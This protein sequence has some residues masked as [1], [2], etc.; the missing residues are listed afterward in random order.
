MTLLNAVL[1]TI[2]AIGGL[3]IVA[4]L[5]LAVACLIA[6]RRDG[7]TGTP[8]WQADFGGDT[9]DAGIGAP[10]TLDEVAKAF[11]SSASPLGDLTDDEILDAL[12]AEDPELGQL[13]NRIDAELTRGAS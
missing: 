6:D 4:A 13:L 12:G 7:R 9:A 2:G 5:V 1:T 11:G 3:S 8:G 10:V